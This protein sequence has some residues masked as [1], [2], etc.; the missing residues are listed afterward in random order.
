VDI[1]GVLFLLLPLTAYFFWESWD[2]V[3]TSWRIREASREAGGLAYPWTPLLKSLLLIMPATVAL[4]GIAMLWRSLRTL[5]RGYRVRP[6][7]ADSED[8]RG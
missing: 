8:I 3:E 2:Y 6:D 7:D 5:R 4:Q 1:G